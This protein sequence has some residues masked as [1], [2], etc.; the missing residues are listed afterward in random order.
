M[1][2][3]SV[4]SESILNDSLEECEGGLNKRK[5]SESQDTVPQKHKRPS[6]QLATLNDG[7]SSLMSP[8]QGSSASALDAVS[9]PAVDDGRI[10]VGGLASRAGLERGGDL[11]GGVGPAAAGGGTSDAASQSPVE[12]QTNNLK[13]SVLGGLGT[14]AAIQPCNFC[15]RTIGGGVVRCDRCD[16]P[17]HAETVCLGVNQASI[18][19]LLG[20]LSGALRYVCCSCRGGWGSGSGTASETGVAF[21]QLLTIVGTLVGEMRSFFAEANSSSSSVRSG[22]DQK[23]PGV[24]ERLVVEQIREVNEREKRKASVI[25]RG[26]RAESAEHLQTEVQQVCSYLQINNVQLS[27]V[28]RIK[29]GMY[30]ANVRNRVDRLKVLTEAR[31]LKQSPEFRDFFIQ[32]DLTYKQRSDLMERRRELGG[33]DSRGGGSGRGYDEGSDGRGRDAGSE[34]RGRG[35]GSEGWGRGVWSGGRGRGVGT[36]YRGVGSGYRG[37]G[38]R[39]LGRDVGSGSRGRPIGSGGRGRGTGLDAQGLGMGSGRGIDAGRGTGSDGQRGGLSFGG[40]G[41]RRAFGRGSSIP[42][43]SEMLGRGRGL[44]DRGPPSSSAGD[45]SSERNEHSQDGPPSNVPRG[46]F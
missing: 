1:E 17:F 40:G 28:F 31:R 35:V 27:D 24:N 7:D 32:R 5:R 45:G 8:A 22:S 46:N 11:E 19:V 30:R 33:A 9:M 25:F 34:G 44:S 13:S 39:G 23:S 3:A 41:G 29:P 15:Q 12:L 42:G 10:A 36:G 6:V 14:V 4:D 16:S 26:S 38:S 18:D 2:K 43:G 20:D 21:Q 37:V